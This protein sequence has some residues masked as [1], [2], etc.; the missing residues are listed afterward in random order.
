MPGCTVRSHHHI[1]HFTIMV[2]PIE[3]AAIK[4]TID[5][6]TGKRGVYHLIENIP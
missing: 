5:G 4:L 2:A 6:E 3:K 1:S